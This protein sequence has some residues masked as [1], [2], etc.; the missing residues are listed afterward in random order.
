MLVQSKHMVHMLERAVEGSVEK[1]RLLVAEANAM[2]LIHAFQWRR[3]QA[4]QFLAHLRWWLL[5]V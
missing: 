4:K 2:T 3:L 1:G 5:D